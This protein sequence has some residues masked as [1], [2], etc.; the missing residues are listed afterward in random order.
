M[1]GRRSTT[2]CVACKRKRRKCDE[3]KPRCQ[4][5][6][7]SEEPCS[8]DYVGYPNTAPHLI[9]RTKPAP[10]PPSESLTRAAKNTSA[11]LELIDT[12]LPVPLDFADPAVSTGFTTTPTWRNNINYR[13][14][15]PTSPGCTIDPLVVFSTSLPHTYLSQSNLS[16]ISPG[17]TQPTTE[18]SHNTTA[19]ISSSEIELGSTRPDDNRFEIIEDPDPEGI[20]ALLFIAL[21]MDKSLK[22]NSLAFVLQSLGHCFRL[23]APQSSTRPE[24]SYY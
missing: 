5:C 23:R 22:E 14:S 24:G 1:I 8:Y 15:F 18:I 6:T 4:R 12:S 17:P 16:H 2:G 13:S 20:Q 19:P 11:V 7:F 10:R 3:V 21:T 9:Q